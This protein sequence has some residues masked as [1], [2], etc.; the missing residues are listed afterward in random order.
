MALVLSGAAVL[1]MDLAGRV[2]PEADIRIDGDRIAAITPA[3]ALAGGGDETID[4]RDALVMPGF[5]NT[6]THLCTGLFRGLVEDIGRETWGADYRIPGQEKFEGADYL[7]SA[8][9]ACQELLLNGVTC[10]ADRWSGMDRI[11]EQ[12]AASGLRAIVGHTLTD[13]SD[14]TEWSIAEALIER[15]GVS[16]DHRITA[17]VA[18]RAPDACADE[19]LRRCARMAERHGCRVFIHAAQSEGEIAKLR[20]RGYDGAL[21]CLQNNGLAGAH[22]IAAH[23]IYLSTAEIARWPAS[24][25]AIAH[26]PASNLKI[27][28][29]TLAIHKLL[30]KT[31][32]GLGTDWAAS[33]NAMDMFA[34]TRIA[35]LV[36]KLLADD[37]TALPVESMLRLATI[38]GARVLGLDGVIGSI[39]PGK[40]ADLIVLDLTRLEANPAHNLGANVIYSMGPRC[41]RD[42]I[43]DGIVLVRSGS[44]TRID[45]EALRREMAQRLRAARQP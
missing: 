21:A 5:V 37:P 30:G 45:V 35:A 1:T 41:V 23:C 10:V 40:R 11:A 31:A 38:D 20:E 26:C 8:Q 36:G 28:A 9:L 16:P 18:P 7:L 2:L 19:I 3:G 27:E 14:A 6:H 4:C 24:R 32:I 34:E 13:R 12:I 44:P 17:G 25:I 22:V 39:E 42:V 15:W 43:V 33:D 29:R